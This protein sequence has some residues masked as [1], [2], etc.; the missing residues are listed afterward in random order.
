MCKNNKRSE[1]RFSNAIHAVKQIEILKSYHL[2][3]DNVVAGKF[4]KT[5]ALTC[6]NSK[7]FYCGNPRK[8]FG[9]QTL[10]EDVSDLNFKEQL[11]DL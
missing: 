2:F 5:N 9:H 8:F 7:C 4:N 1:R 6:G 3:H 11:D 10:K